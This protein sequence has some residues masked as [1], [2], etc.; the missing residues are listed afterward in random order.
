MM[1]VLYMARWQPEDVAVTWSERSDEI[2]RYAARFERLMTH[3]SVLPSGSGGTFCLS[4]RPI[5]AWQQRR[6]TPRDTQTDDTGSCPDVES[7]QQEVYIVSLFTLLVFHSHIFNRPICHLPLHQHSATFSNIELP[8]QHCP[9][10]SPTRQGIAYLVHFQAF[11][12]R[13]SH[14]RQKLTGSWRAGS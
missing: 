11:H 4:S 13:K 1:L 7:F 10:A 2:P 9:S 3:S 12:G 6:H 14:V 8:P 5:P